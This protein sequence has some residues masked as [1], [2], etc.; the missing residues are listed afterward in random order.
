M[1]PTA[2]RVLKLCKKV[3][4]GAKLDRIVDGD[5]EDIVWFLTSVATVVSH[6]TE[7]GKRRKQSRVDS[8]TPTDEA[9]A[10]MTLECHRDKFVPKRTERDSTQRS[11]TAE[12]NSGEKEKKKR[13]AG[14]GASRECYAK[15]TK[16]LVEWRNKWKDKHCGPVGEWLEK[17]R[18][19]LQGKDKEKEHQA[20]EDVVDEAALDSGFSLELEMNPSFMDAGEVQG[21]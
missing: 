4:G 6:K 8:V 20:T 11:E 12:G 2:D 14:S 9:F 16:E 3:F 7:A 21:V 1:P 17:E 13:I 15:K 18:K 10:L 19:V 5:K